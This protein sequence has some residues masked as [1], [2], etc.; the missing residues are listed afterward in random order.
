M[1]NKNGFI[2][3]SWKSLSIPWFLLALSAKSPNI[4]HSSCLPNSWY[5]SLGVSYNSKWIHNILDYCL[6]FLK[7]GGFYHAKK[8]IW[9]LMRSLNF[10]VWLDLVRQFLLYLYCY[11]K[12]LPM[13]SNVRST[14]AVY[15]EEF[16]VV[17]WNIYYFQC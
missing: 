15:S 9:Y 11:L 8:S 7:S 5:R 3:F 1:I 16:H 10:F 2:T 17:Y 13:A 4:R 14:V 12:G 6:K